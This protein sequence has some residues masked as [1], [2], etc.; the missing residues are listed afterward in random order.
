MEIYQLKVFLQVARCLSFTEAADALNLTQP[1]VSAKIKSLESE[2]G[3]SLFYRLGRKVQLTDLGTFLLEEAPKLVQQEEKLLQQI[4]EF[5]QGNSGTLKIGCSPAISEGWAPRIIYEYRQ[6]YPGIR[7]K[8]NIFDSCHSLYEAVTDHSID[9]GFSET[10]FTD[11]SELSIRA[12]DQMSYRLI[13]SPTHPLAQQEW[14]SL[15]ELGQERLVTLSENAASRLLFEARLLELGLSL[16]HFPQLESVD[17][18][19]LMRTYILQGNYVGFVSEFELWNECESGHLVAIPI[20][21]FALSADVFLLLPKRIDQVLIHSREEGKKSKQIISPLQK[22]LDLLSTK[23]QLFPGRSYKDEDATDLQSVPRFRSL[24]YS[25]LSFVQ[26]AVEDLEISIG[27]QNSTIPTVAAGIITQKLGLLEHY[28][29][30]S[31]KYSQVKYQIKW[32]D[33]TFGT[34]IVEGLHTQK[35]DIGV[36]GD[37]PLLLSAAR[38]AQSQGQLE[39]TILVSFIGVNPD[40]SANAVLV[41]HDS[42]LHSVEDLQGQIIATPLGSSAHGM[43]LRVLS[44]FNLSSSVELCSM[45]ESIRKSAGRL[46]PIVTGYAH[47][48]PFHELALQQGGLRYLFKGDLGEL[49]GFYGVVVRRN[50]AEHHPDL[51]ISYLRALLAS[52]YWQTHVP[53]AHYLISQWVQCPM[54]L[55]QKTFGDHPHSRDHS[56]YVPD[57]QIRSDWVASHIQQ[58]HGPPD[59]YPFQSINLDQWIQPEFLAAALKQRDS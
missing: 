34:P 16:D 38:S 6:R 54:E 5:K 43:L 14:G 57:P 52:Q 33:F 28:L 58:F 20:Q 1:A 19:S 3:S 48:S 21:E 24:R 27:V 45:D 7:T 25:S 59:H 9:V 18:L 2:L 36:L 15:R 51:V 8:L 56:L 40:G 46:N 53:S 26:K 31:G 17:T 32:H 41:P 29:P 12:I 35:L 10:E 4:D 50:F 23:P 22:L 37:Y 47:F 44:K 55:I 30:R 49:P 39:H 42:P 13:A 11:F